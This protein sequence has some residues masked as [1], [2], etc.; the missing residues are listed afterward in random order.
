MPQHG[1]EQLGL[2]TVKPSALY[3][4]SFLA[5]VSQLDVLIG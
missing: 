5:A 2:F 1:S 3:L 4:I